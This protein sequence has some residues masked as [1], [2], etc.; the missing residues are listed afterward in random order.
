VAPRRAE[1]TL[2]EDN[3]KLQPPPPRNPLDMAPYLEP[4]APDYVLGPGD[5]ISVD[6]AGVPE[7]ARRGLLVR[8]DGKV[9]LFLLDDVAVTGKRPQDVALELETKLSTFVPRPDVVVTVDDIRSQRFYVLGAVARPGVYPI[10]GP[11]TVLEALALSGG[12]LMGGEN[13]RSASDFSRAYLLRGSSVVPV[14]FDK[15]LAGDRSH[16][17]YLRAQDLLYVPA[18][19][20]G[21][22]AVLGQVNQPRVLEHDGSLT[23]ME[24]LAACGWVTIDG[25]ETAVRIIRGSLAE[26]RVYV[27]DAEDI[28][29]GDE[30]DGELLPGDIVYV[31]TTEI[32]DWNEV[33]RGILPTLQAALAARFILDGFAIFPPSN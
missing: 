14:N 25:K 9:T 33:I 21:E 20:K 13:A 24:A 1:N 3:W 5:R 6:V 10:D 8:P 19:W 26:P 32:A 29:A 7:L 23:L 2:E 22:V 17:V 18:R 11:L 15:L 16:N 31:T 27:L 4:R 28:A 12:G 30:K